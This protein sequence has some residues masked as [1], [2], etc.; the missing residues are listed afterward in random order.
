MVSVYAVGITQ[1]CAQ[2]KKANSKEDKARA[3]AQVK[4]AQD[5]VERY[6]NRPADQDEVPD[7]QVG[8]LEEMLMKMEKDNEGKFDEIM[9]IPP[10]GTV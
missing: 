1:S 10:G 2:L 3:Q 8:T 9:F 7:I 6:V 5:R 4:I